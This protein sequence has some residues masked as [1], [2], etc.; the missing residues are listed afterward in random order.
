MIENKNF[1]YDGQLRKYLLQFMS[2]F[3]GLQVQTGVQACGTPTMV[4]VPCT[5]GNKDR[6]VAAISA[7][8]TQNRVFGL[9]IMATSIVGLTIA[10]ARRKAPDMEDTR[11]YLPVGGVFPDD[12]R[13]V[14][15]VMPVPYDMQVELS[16]Y[17][18]NT[19]QMHQ[20]LEQVLCLFNPELQIQVS[21][22]TFDWTRLTHVRLTDIANEENYPAGPD[23]R[24]IVWTLQF[25]IPI[26]IG[27]PVGLRDE[28]VRKVRIRMGTVSGDGS[29]SGFSDEQGNWVPYDEIVADWTI[30]DRKPVGPVVEPAKPFPG[31]PQQ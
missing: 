13:Q 2:I 28:I 25:E 5:A 29:N 24:V 21:R 4:P 30:T 14:E 1:W 6:V 8:N 31:Y 18:S 17:A 19:Q 15:R 27:V 11:T 3:Y 10:D 16:I 23:R 22:G 7:G 26:F 9:P 12:L 20:I